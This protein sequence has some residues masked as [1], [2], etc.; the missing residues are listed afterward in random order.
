MI[1]LLIRKNQGCLSQEKAFALHNFKQCWSTVDFIS[2]AQPYSKANLEIRQYHLKGF[3]IH[4]QLKQ[5]LKF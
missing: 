5:K 1:V 3:W 4:E 2:S